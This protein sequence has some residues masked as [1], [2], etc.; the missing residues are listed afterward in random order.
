[1]WYMRA[2]GRSGWGGRRGAGLRASLHLRLRL[3]PRQRPA[4]ALRHVRQEAGRKRARWLQ[5]HCTRV[6][7]GLLIKYGH[8][9]NMS[10]SLLDVS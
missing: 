10:I 6:R 1:M 8:K 4:T 5:R 3:R 9:N 7:T 2:G